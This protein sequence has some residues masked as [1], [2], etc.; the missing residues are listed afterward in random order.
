MTTST[1]G[2]LLIILSG[3]VFVIFIVIVRLV[4]TSLNPVQAAFMRY[5]MSLVIVLPMLYRQGTVIFHTRHPLRHAARGAVHGL[6]VLLWFYAITSMPIAEATALSY[7]SPLFVLIG[8]TLFLGERLRGWTVFAVA[9]GFVGVL[10][11]VRPG[12]MTISPGAIAILCSAPLFAASQLLVKSLVR[13]D[14][15][16]TTVIYLSL[17]ATLTM[18]VP[19]IAVWEAPGMVDIGLMA[20]AALFATLS[21]ILMAQ[22]FKLVDVSVVQPVEFLRLVWA[23][24]F[25]FFLFN[26]T[27][28]MWVWIGSLVVVASVTLAV[29]RTMAVPAS[30]R[31][32]DV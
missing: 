20:V 19:A 1:R 30:A 23:A 17:F 12:F 22:G 21:H 32:S 25:G 26:E 9:S 15:S 28:T 3:F 14:S 7:I 2:L 29:N 16:I 10:I 8:A 18:L 24:L 4:G 27:P 31:S 5:A 11:I 6:G 13:E